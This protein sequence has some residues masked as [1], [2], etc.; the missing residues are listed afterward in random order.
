MCQNPVLRDQQIEKG[1][2]K[3]ADK[4]GLAF[5]TVEAFPAE[6]GRRAESLERS[7]PRLSEKARPCGDSGSPV[8]VTI[9]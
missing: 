1:F 2:A 3:V 4:M 6:R 8:F 7:I 5:A 9:R